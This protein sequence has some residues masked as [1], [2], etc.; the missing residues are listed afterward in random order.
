[1]KY[2]NT[3]PME[4]LGFT[5]EMKTGK[6]ISGYLIFEE[7]SKDVPIKCYGGNGIRGYVKE[8]NEEGCFSIIGY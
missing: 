6:E 3:I 2:D 4:K 7:K 8:P 5:F 1:M